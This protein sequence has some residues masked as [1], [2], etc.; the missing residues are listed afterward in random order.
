MKADLP[1]AQEAFTTWNHIRFK[2]RGVKRKCIIYAYLGAQLDLIEP[3]Q[4]ILYL[5]SPPIFFLVMNVHANYLEYASDGSASV[6]Q[7]E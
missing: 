6:M 5:F 4:I 3:F 1:F 2:L 7:C